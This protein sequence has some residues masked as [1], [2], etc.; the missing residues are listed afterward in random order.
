[1]ESRREIDGV[2][3]LPASGSAAHVSDHRNRCTIVALL[4]MR[5]EI[6]VPNVAGMYAVLS[7]Y[8]HPNPVEL[9]R[10]LV[11]SSK[12]RSQG[13]SVT[14][15]HLRQLVGSSVAASLPGLSTPGHVSRM[16]P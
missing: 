4:A 1:M 5:S 16:G 15:S 6:C 14:P 7:A 3:P 10:R 12:G 2:Q 9:Q 13:L 8:V 11:P